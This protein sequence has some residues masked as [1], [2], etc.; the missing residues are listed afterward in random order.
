MISLVVNVLLWLS[1]LYVVFRLAD[2]DNDRGAYLSDVWPIFCIPLVVMVYLS[3]SPWP[4]AL[5]ALRSGL[6]TTTLGKFSR[7]VVATFTISSY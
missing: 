1:L 4:A 7:R 6:A 5:R 2:Y 3:F